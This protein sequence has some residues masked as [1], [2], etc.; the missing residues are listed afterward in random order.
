MIDKTKLNVGCGLRKR[1]DFIN[2][3]F[4]ETVNPDIIRDITRGLPFDDNKFTQIY[5]SH[6]LEHI[7]WE[8]FIFVMQEFWRVCQSGATVEI[9]VPYYKFAGAYDIDHRIVLTPRTFDVFTH[10]TACSSDYRFNKHKYYYKVIN[11]FE[12][13]N[14]IRGEP[15]LYMTLEVIKNG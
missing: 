4:D 9:I 11:T 7:T 15:Q 12:D 6:V 13:E 10:R 1:N 14:G 3:D 8:D 5:C 2:L